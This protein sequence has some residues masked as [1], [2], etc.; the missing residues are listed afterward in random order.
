M[1]IKSAPN[2]RAAA[3]TSSKGSP[4][5]QRRY[6]DAVALSILSRQIQIPAALFFE[7]R[8]H[9]L[10][11]PFAEADKLIQNQFIDDVENGHL[12]RRASSDYAKRHLHGLKRWF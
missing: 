8:F 12:A 1:M 3:T 5:R 2:W 9:F 10:W 6:G 4:L 11:A 7:F